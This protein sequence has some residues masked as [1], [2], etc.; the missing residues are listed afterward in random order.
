MYI[1]EFDKNFFTFTV[2]H[3]SKYNVHKKFFRMLQICIPKPSVNKYFCE[4]N[5]IN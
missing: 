1:V 5:S 2:L 3:Y 4:E